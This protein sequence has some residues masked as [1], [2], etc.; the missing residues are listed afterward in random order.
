MQRTFR[1]IAVSFP[2]VLLAFFCS[3][4]KA[5]PAATAPPTTTPHGPNQKMDSAFCGRVLAGA[6]L[7]VARHTR[8]LEESPQIPYPGGD[9]PADTG[10]CTD[11]VIRAF[12]HA[13]LDLQKAV[14]EDRVAHIDAYPTQIWST[15]KSD[16]SIDHRRCPNLQAWFRRHALSLPTSADDLA[17]SDFQPG[18]VVFFIKA[19][20][21]FPWHVA[22]VSDRMS[23]AEPRVPMLI[24]GFPPETSESHRLDDFG[25]I[26]GHFRYVA[27]PN[28]ARS[29]SQGS[30]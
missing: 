28:E 4:G 3:L 22:I 30:D 6:R 11:L 29:A 8:Y 24:D 15:K 2:C 19:K 21:S 20:A 1:Y 13:G 14:H 26:S 17:S 16:A 10:V 9:V 27:P 18:D 12:R 7:E 23:D 5:Q 25:P